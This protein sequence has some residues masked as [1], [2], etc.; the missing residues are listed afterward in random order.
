MKLQPANKYI[1]F[2]N[3]FFYSYLVCKEYYYKDF[4]NNNLLIYRQNSFK[5]LNLL[6]LFETF[7][8]LV[9]KKSVLHNWKIK[10]Y[11]RH[12]L[13]LASFMIYYYK[14]ALPLDKYYVNTQKYGILVNTY[15][16]TA[17][18]ENFNIPK[19]YLIMLKFLSFYNLLNL[20]YYEITESYTYYNIIY[21]N[22]KYYAIFILI[23]AFYHI[24]IVIPSTL[25]Y[26]KK[27]IL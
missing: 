12:H 10:D 20:I 19:K 4:S 9:Y 25:K 3:L 26:L 5:L 1:I 15:E 2:N 18:L 23:A 7:I 24:T 8:A 13:L 16:I 11:L 6:Y 17:L 14:Y 21:S 22:K 27:N